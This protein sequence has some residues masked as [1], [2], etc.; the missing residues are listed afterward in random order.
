[1]KPK[2]DLWASIKNTIENVTIIL[3]LTPLYLLTSIFAFFSK[4]FIEFKS[5]QKEYL[6]CCFK[7]IITKAYYINGNNN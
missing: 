4:E 1:M 2:F 5:K 3:A 6:K 7:T